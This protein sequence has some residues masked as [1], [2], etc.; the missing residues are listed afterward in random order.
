MSRILLPWENL[1]LHCSEILVPKPFLNLSLL[2]SGVY[3]VATIEMITYSQI[4]SRPLKINIQASWGETD[5]LWVVLS[6]W[7]KR[8]TNLLIELAIPFSTKTWEALMVDE[9]VRLRLHTGCPLCRRPQQ[10]KLNV[11]LP[12]NH[13]Q[14]MAI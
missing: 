6:I 8:I 2:K 1:L 7:P 3:L 4:Q 11:L 5:T 12:P 9:S 14:P 10:W 13:L